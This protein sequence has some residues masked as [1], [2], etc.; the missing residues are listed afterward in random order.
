M[1][2]IFIINFTFMQYFLQEGDIF[3]SLPFCGWFFIFSA[4]KTLMSLR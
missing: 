2:E 1:M 3:P 4:Y